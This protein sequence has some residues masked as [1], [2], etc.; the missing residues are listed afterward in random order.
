MASNAWEELSNAVRRVAGEAGTRG[1]IEIIFSCKDRSD[2]HRLRD[3]FQY[4][5]MQSGAN[6]VDRSIPSVSR[7]CGL[8]LRFEDA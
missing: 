7:V 2:K 3:R 5:V 1:E 6:V 8:T 4:E